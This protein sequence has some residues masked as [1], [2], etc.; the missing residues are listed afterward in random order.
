[1][2]QTIMKQLN[3]L[4]Q[5]VWLDYISRSLIK[6]GRLAELIS[7]GITGMTSNPTIFYQAIRAGGEYDEQIRELKQKGKSIFEIYD[8]ITIADIQAAAD[9]FKPVY[10][11]T[12]GLDGYVSLAINPKLA[13]TT[14]EKT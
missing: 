6:S 11:R 14:R 3:A 8:D 2:P 10:E 4:G 12:K 13:Y 9:I 7:Q 1:M 5:S